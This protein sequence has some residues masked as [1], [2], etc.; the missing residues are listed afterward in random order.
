MGFELD[1]VIKV[2]IVAGGNHDA[3]DAA[4]P[5]SR[6]GEGRRGDGSVT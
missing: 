5:C 4:P 2:G 1:A 6:K 3:E